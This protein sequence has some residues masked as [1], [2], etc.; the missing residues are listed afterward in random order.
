M[1]N[2]GDQ[3]RFAEFCQ[4]WQRINGECHAAAQKEVDALG[5][6]AETGAVCEVLQA[7]VVDCLGQDPALCEC[8]CGDYA[9]D[10][11]TEC[12][13]MKNKKLQNN[14][15]EIITLYTTFGDCN[16][17]DTCQQSLSQQQVFMAVY[18]TRGEV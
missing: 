12:V 16:L 11:E 4:R 5:A 1:K 8:T 17:Q 10:P 2:R 7:A 14:M 6:D 15:K 13:N 18:S 3:I 9:K